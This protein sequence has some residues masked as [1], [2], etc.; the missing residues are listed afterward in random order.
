MT[1]SQADLTEER[2]RGRI[3]GAATIAAGALIGAGIVWDGFANRDRPDG[4]DDDAERL[5]FFDDHSVE[6]IAANGLRSAGFLLLA[7]TIVHLQRATKARNPELASVPL[8]IGLAGAIAL[9]IGF[10]GH[11]V[12]LG[13]EASDFAT[14]QFATPAA[15]D[16]AAE[17]A[18]TQGLPLLSGIFAFA[19]TIAVSFWFVIASLNAMRVGL[20]TRFMGVLGIIVGPG[21]IFG[22]APPVM[23]FWLIAVGILFLGRWPRGVPPAWEAGVAV[24]WP[25]RGRRSEPDEEAVEPAPGSQNGEV[26]P[27]GPGVRKPEPEQGPGSSSP[28]SRRKRKRRR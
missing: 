26:E 14:R 24:P 27:V 2:R 11:A 18:A 22:F 6:L 19:G 25:S 1:M 23:V 17:D 8:V 9:G 15:A 13:A 7:F 28:A 4:K 20:L 16:K 10:V 21:F 5:R 3:A 12:A